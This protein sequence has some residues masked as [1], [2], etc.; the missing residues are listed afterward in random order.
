MDSKRL[1]LK[2]STTVGAGGTD[3]FTATSAYT[4]GYINVYVNGSRLDALLTLLR[5]L[6]LLVLSH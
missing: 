4:S 2:N 6:L 5:Q 3:I 1:S